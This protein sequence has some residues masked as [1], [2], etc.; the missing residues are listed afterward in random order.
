[1]SAAV[2]PLRPPRLTS[3]D[4]A[5][6]HLAG[7]ILSA[8]RRGLDVETIAATIAPRHPSTAPQAV[9]A[10]LLSTLAELERMAAL[11]CTTAARVDC[12]GDV[13]PDDLE[14]GA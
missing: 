12:Q 7:E 6:L 8:H 13:R 11:G 4:A 10:V 9:I 3:G 14:D 2:H 1:M 5:A